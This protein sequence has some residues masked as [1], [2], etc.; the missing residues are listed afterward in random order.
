MALFDFETQAGI[1]HVLASIRAS[2]ISP[3]QKNELRDIVF[4]YAN[5]G[6]DQTVKLSLEQKLTAYAIVALPKKYAA[7][8][9]PMYTIGGTR[10]APDEF[11]VVNS[12]KVSP[13]PPPPPVAAP[14]PAP[15]VPPV[16]PPPPPPPVQNVAPAPVSSVPPPMPVAPPPP[17]AAAPQPAP[18]VPPAPV[19]PPPPPVQNVAP[20]QAAPST[21]QPA[22]VD[23]PPAGEQQLQ[24]I[25]EIK[26]LVNEQVGNPV[27]LIDIDNE[28]GREYMGAL[29]D[30]MKK[31]NTGTSSVAAMQRLEQ[32]YQTVD[33]AIKRHKGVAAQSNIKPLAQTVPVQVAPPPP[34]Q[35][36]VVPPPPVAAPQ[37]A[38]Y[39]PP[40]PIV[41]PPPPVAAPRPVPPPVA[42]P[43]P[44]IPPPV[45]AAPQ[46]APY[47]P[48]APVAPP[49]QRVVPPPLPPV[50]PVAVPIRQ[51][52]DASSAWE[53]NKPSAS[54]Y[55][56]SKLTSL[57]ESKLRAQPPVAPSAAPAAPTDPLFAP[58][59][60]SGLDQLLSE[61]SLFKK[62]GLF[63]TGPKGR[64][65]PL[66]KKIAGLQ[67]PL[68]L[69]GRFEGATQEIKQSIT[70]YMNG[71]RYEQGIIYMPGE[72]FERYL[73]RV[74]RHI[75][76][77]Q[78]KLPRT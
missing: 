13:P 43:Q 48:P 78:K 71:W 66:F 9:A 12:V 28:A 51:A 3:A 26:S 42:A 19:A 60:D 53:S 49:P 15:Y 64:E 59:I 17:V 36:P 68:L 23:F 22:A 1:T 38:P 63:G 41:P 62:S 61:W 11:A 21:P 57:A 8:K 27:N 7:P 75:L 4:L 65:H 45:A 37:P 74:I 30:A 56:D 20:V 40:A 44:V 70:D 69:A 58:E 24:R 72:T 32:A 55:A 39:V 50:A 2:S 16:A 47:V 67:I 25:R 77:L 35:M 76:D 73:R 54:A 6:H 34:P 10:Q 5:G 18:Y 52:E 46:P 29:L 33:A 14:Q 31:L